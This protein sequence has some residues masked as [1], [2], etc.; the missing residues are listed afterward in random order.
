MYPACKYFLLL[1]TSQKCQWKHVAQGKGSREQS[2]RE[3]YGLGQITVLFPRS[4]FALS[5][6]TDP[7]LVSNATD[8]SIPYLTTAE[9]H[10][11]SFLAYNLAAFCN[12]IPR[13]HVYP[14]AGLFLL[15]AGESV[16]GMGHS[17]RM[18]VISWALPG[19]SW[20]QHRCVAPRWPPL[21]REN[22]TGVA[23]TAHIWIYFKM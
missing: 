2:Q 5:P 3:I 16:F 6:P 9:D 18:G 23:K 7:T 10:L 12:S 4:A 1:Q 19:L 14:Q 20:E 17:L 22:C 8:L 21:H 13:T 15:P 11:L